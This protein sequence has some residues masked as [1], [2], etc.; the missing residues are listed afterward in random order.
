MIARSP[1]WRRTGAALLA[2]LAMLLLMA[3][4]VWAA[5]GDSA[6]GQH[7]DARPIDAKVGFELLGIR[8]IN[9]LSG[10]YEA[11]FNLSFKTSAPCEPAGFLIENGRI[12][13]AVPVLK[14][15]D[16]KVYRVRAQLTFD[17][18]TRKIPFENQDLAIQLRAEDPGIRYEMDPDATP[19]S[20]NLSVVDW[21]PG[22]QLAVTPMDTSKI[23]GKNRAFR[24]QYG[25]S[26]H[27]SVAWSILRFMLPALAL[28]SSAFLVL[29]LPDDFKSRLGMALAAFIGTVFLQLSV[30]GRVPIRGGLPF[31]DKYQVISYI[32]ISIVIAYLFIDNALKEKDLTE[33]RARL[34]GYVRALLPTAW[35]VVMATVIVT[36]FR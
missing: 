33:K 16:H 30:G 12:Q 23:D 36:T 32:T 13:S 19:T 10:E 3:G 29:V 9:M 18:D 14:E 28:T 31:W 26:V 11:L 2:V 27:R 20:L 25:V 22:T 6:T 21:V 24:Y 1:F 5:E 8:N 17:V 4:T 34:T 7:A 35:L 15:P